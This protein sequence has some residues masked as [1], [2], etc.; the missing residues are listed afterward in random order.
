MLLVPVQTNYLLRG[1]KK[2]YSIKIIVKRKAQRSDP[3]IL[4]LHFLSDRINSYKPNVPVRIERALKAKAKL[5]LFYST[6]LLLPLSSPDIVPFTR[7]LD[8]DSARRSRLTSTPASRRH[9]SSYERI[10]I[11]RGSRSHNENVCAQRIV[12]LVDNKLSNAAQEDYPDRFVAS[13]RFTGTG[14]E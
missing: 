7:I 2:F 9:P 1:S 8:H 5:S 12:R 6:P 13:R 3:N 11:T 10:L 14:I 4:S